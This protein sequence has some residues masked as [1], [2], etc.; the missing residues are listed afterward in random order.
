LDETYYCNG[1]TLWIIKINGEII[2]NITILEDK[3][4]V[5]EKVPINQNHIHIKEANNNISKVFTKRER[6]DSL[7]KKENNINNIK[8]N[9]NKKMEENNTKSTTI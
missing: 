8:T 7:L 9:R 6:N 3:N 5:D 1:N 4:N 2:K